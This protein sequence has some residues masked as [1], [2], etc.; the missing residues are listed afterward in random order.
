MP[1]HLV[2]H[3]SSSRRNGASLTW[4]P[5]RS[6]LLAAGTANLTL[7]PLPCYDP[8][9]RDHKPRTGAAIRAAR[10]A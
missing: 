1:T 7:M 9:R 6:G 8:R 10:S 3:L 2:R 4:R 5:K